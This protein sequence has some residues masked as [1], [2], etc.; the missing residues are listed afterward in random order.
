MAAQGHFT[1]PAKR[2]P[3]LSSDG[4]AIPYGASVWQR[5]APGKVADDV[6]E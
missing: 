5:A 4:R 3:F 2:R 1:A 6:D